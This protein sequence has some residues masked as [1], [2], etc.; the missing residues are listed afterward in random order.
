MKGALIHGL[1]SAV[2]VAACCRCRTVLRNHVLDDA[3]KSFREANSGEAALRELKPLAYLGDGTAQSLIGYAYALGW[4][5]VQRHETEAI[6]WFRR[7]GPRAGTGTRGSAD[8]AAE[9]EL[10][11]ADAY[12]NGAD[13]AVRDSVESIKWLRL[14]AKSGSKEAVRLLRDREAALTRP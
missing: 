11:V 2:V 1:L 10:A 9:H 6:Y 12:A 3:T 13:G 5:G 14:A 7:S 4:G 8:P